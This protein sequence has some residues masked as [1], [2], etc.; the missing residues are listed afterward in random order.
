MIYVYSVYSEKI[1]NRILFEPVAK[2]ADRLCIITK[3]AT[4]GMASW[5]IT[6]Y[7]E[8]K[9][10]NIEIN[11]II[12]STC[13]KGISKVD[14]EEF[15]NLQGNRN[16]NKTSCFTCSYLFQSLNLKNNFYIWFKN[17]K[18]IQIFE[19]PYDFTQASL[20]RKHNVIS[21]DVKTRISLK[22]YDKIIKNS[23]FCNHSEIEEYIKIQSPNVFLKDNISHSDNC[24]HLSLLTK[25]NEIGKKSG[26]NWGQ[27]G[28][29]NPNEAYIPLP[30]GIARSGFFP[31]NKQHFMTITDDRH[32]LLLRVEQQ[33]NKAITTPLSNALLGEYFRNRLGLH[34]GAYVTVNDLKRYGRTDVTFYKID[35]EQYY[36]DFSVSG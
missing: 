3:Y 18:I 25:N 13:D 10:E 22:I 6:T 19:C 26:L 17:G 4:P 8:R 28:N 1:V 9:K 12:C 29:R 27:R 24:V 20:L 34:N 36:M 2:G 11:L 35:E 15:R 5:L 32:T 30:V 16:S 14:H 7:R 21:E 33:N 31:L 23:I